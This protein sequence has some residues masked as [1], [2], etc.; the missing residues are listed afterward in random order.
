MPR[1]YLPEAGAPVILQ[2]DLRTWERAET[3]HFT[4]EAISPG[5]VWGSGSP[6]SPNRGG[7][8]TSSASALAS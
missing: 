2:G 1:Y 3:S 7:A 8:L 5:R 4:A 6:P